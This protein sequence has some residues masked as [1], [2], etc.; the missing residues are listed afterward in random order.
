PPSLLLPP[1][2]GLVTVP[3]APVGRR[4]P[5]QAAALVWLSTLSGVVSVAAIHDCCWVRGALVR[6]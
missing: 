4:K 3:M 6:A 2:P 5:Q 1:L